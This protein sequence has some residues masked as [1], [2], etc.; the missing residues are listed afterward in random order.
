MSS[1]LQQMLSQGVVPAPA[2]A[3]GG[4]RAGAARVDVGQGD[5]VDLQCRIHN[6]GLSTSD[7]AGAQLSHLPCAYVVSGLIVDG[8]LEQDNLLNTGLAFDLDGDGQAAGAVTARPMEDGAILARGRRFWPTGW[9]YSQRFS[10]RGQPVVGRLGERG[11]GFCFHYLTGPYA[12][13]G[14]PATPDGS[15]EVVELP[16]PSLHIYLSAPALDASPGAPPVTV[17]VV[18]ID[19]RA[20][21]PLL[22]HCSMYHSP[23]TEPGFKAGWRRSLCLTVPLP[24]RAGVTEWSLRLTVKR[25][26][27]LPLRADLVPAWS[28]GPDA[29]HNGVPASV[30]F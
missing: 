4:L 24:L 11:P 14:L 16:N 19:E 8:A 18:R 21:E 25:T 29:C 7:L 10:V 1:L 17:D 12:S 6:S 5:A 3:G 13:L 26:G 20:V 9:P 28:T 22:P 27:S 15:L 23:F 30:P 2:E